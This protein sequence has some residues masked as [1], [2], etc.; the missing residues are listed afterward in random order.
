MI[1]SAKGA[2]CKGECMKMA[3]QS[4]TRAMEQGLTAAQ[5]REVVANAL[6]EQ[7]RERNQQK[8]QMDEQAFGARV[9]ERVRLTLAEKAGDRE[10]KRG[11]QPVIDRALPGEVGPDEIEPHPTLPR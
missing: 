4:M 1:Q 2:E 5:S 9:Q 3:I 11:V 6:R 8:L 7:A 10:H